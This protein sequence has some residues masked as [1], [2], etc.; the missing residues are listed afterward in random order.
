[1]RR[2]KWVNTRNVLKYSSCWSEDH[3]IEFEQRA[4]SHRLDG[5]DWR[6][7]M[8]LALIL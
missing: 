1:M 6:Y 7:Y 2:M 3:H 5:P 8:F 4:D